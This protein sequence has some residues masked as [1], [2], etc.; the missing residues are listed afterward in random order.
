MGVYG[1]EPSTSL[2]SCR[3]HI[4]RAWLAYRHASGG[5]SELAL[6]RVRRG[7]EGS[8]DNEIVVK[9]K[10]Q[11]FLAVSAQMAQSIVGIRPREEEACPCCEKGIVQRW[12][13]LLKLF[14]QIKVVCCCGFVSTRAGFDLLE[15]LA[16]TPH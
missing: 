2:H 14:K 3:V 4:S 9:S 16:A 8:N 12:M 1:R 6:G 5:E 10:M 7:C 13:L 11:F 15:S